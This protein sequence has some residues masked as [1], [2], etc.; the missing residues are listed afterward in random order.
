[1]EGGLTSRLLPC[2][3]EQYFDRTPSDGMPPSSPRRQPTTTS[4]FSYY[5]VRMG[6]HVHVGA[7]SIVE[8]AVIGS[9]IDIGRGCVLGK[10][11][12]LKDCIRILD[13]AVIPQGAVLAS[14]TVWAGSPGA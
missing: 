13:G 6:D 12:V 11:S 4:L 7:D 1:M 3:Q 2:Q 9:H 8:S 14:G 10:L 5:T